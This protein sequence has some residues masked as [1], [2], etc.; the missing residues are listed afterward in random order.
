MSTGASVHGARKQ[1]LLSLGGGGGLQEPVCE[2][3]F[4]ANREKNGGHQK[5]RL[6][7]LR[8]PAVFHATLG[9]VA[10]KIDDLEQREAAHLSG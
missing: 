5:S 6:K 1:T 3:F 8:F 10:F 9:L 7:I 2:V 4:V